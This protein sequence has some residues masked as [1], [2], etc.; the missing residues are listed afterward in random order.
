VF[1]RRRVIELEKLDM[2]MA[3]ILDYEY[4]LR[5][6]ARGF[7][8]YHI[9]GLIAADRQYSDRISVVHKEEAEIMA[10]QLRDRLGIKTSH[11]W[12]WRFFDRSLQG[13]CRLK[14]FFHLVKILSDRRLDDKL[15]FGGKIDSAW[16][17]GFRQLFRSIT[18]VK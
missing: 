14:G 1:F 3:L 10:R 5:L 7:K 9:N 8:F 12:M 4:W 6:G 2:D 16:K 13:Y 18:Q 11:Q 17:L 15:A